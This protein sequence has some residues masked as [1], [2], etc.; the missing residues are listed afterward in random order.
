[1][2][3]LATNDQNIADFASDD[4]KDDFVSHY[5]IKDTEIPHSQLELGYRVRPEPFDRLACCCRL[6][7]ESRENRG[8]DRPAITRRQ[9]LQL[10]IGLVGDR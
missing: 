5:V 3:L 4:Q 8:F 7:T 10:H 1:M 2:E 6:V 9:C